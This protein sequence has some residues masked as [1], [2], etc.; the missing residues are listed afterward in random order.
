MAKLPFPLQ[1]ER[2][3]AAP[4]DPDA[5]FDTVADMNTY[6]T[7]ARRYEGQVVSC[8]ETPGK[9]YTLNAALDGWVA[10]G[11][12]EAATE[13]DITLSMDVGALDA[14]TI[15]PADT[16][17][18]DVLTSLLTKI[19]NPTFT[20]PSAVLSSS[21]GNNVEAGTNAFDLSVAFNTGAI[22]GDLDGSNIWDAGLKQDD[23]AGAANNYTIDGVDNDL[24]TTLARTTTIDDGANVF[25]CQV[26][27]DEGVQPVDSAGANYDSPLAA[28]N[29]TDTVTINGRR[30]LFYGMDSAG[31]TSADI[32]ALSDNQLNPSNGTTFT[33]NI[34][35]GTTSVLFAY[36][37]SLQSV[38][39]VKYVEG[40]NAEVR[41]I[42]T[43]T[44]VDVEGA[45]AYTAVAYRV[46]R[47]Q[48]VEVYAADATYTVTI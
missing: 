30:N 11:D 38:S 46:Y 40:M 36:P 8:K 29:V 10:A 23:R 7:N 41:G 44:A 31:V 2:Q 4:I 35:A 47:F 32:R 20:A 15:I 19:F 25:N 5:V 16:S 43:E 21:V 6:L 33:L 26:D 34:P 12:G 27:Y 45:N 42:F 24:V 14:G 13:A 48:P 17:L 37:A 3:Y 9:L 39:S 28:G 1:I 18:Q 22:T